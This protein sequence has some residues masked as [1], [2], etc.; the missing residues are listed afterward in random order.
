MMIFILFCDSG[1][2]TQVANQLNLYFVSFFQQTTGQKRLSAGRPQEQADAVTWKLCAVVSVMDSVKVDKLSHVTA[3][4]RH[5]LS[6][7]PK[8]MKTGISG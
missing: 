8:S 1:L 7:T 2:K 6:Y 4:Q 3:N 5:K